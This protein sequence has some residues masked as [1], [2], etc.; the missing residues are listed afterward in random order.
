MDQYLL[1]P[2]VAH[3]LGVSPATLRKWRSQRRGPHFI[4][5]GDGARGRV[6]YSLTAVEAWLEA[7]RH[8]GN[9]RE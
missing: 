9:E 1:S 8:A 7:R 6:L 3:R 4:R 2:Q 5:L